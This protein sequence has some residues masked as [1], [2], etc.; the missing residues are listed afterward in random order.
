ATLY[1][2][3]TGRVPHEAP[4][5]EALYRRIL[6]A[7]VSR[8]GRHNPQAP[9]ELEIVLATALERDPLRRYH[10]AEAFADDLQ[11][12]RTRRPI[13]ARSPGP[14]LRVRRWSQRYPYVAALLAVLGASL[15]VVVYLLSDRNEALWQK[16]MALRRASAALAT[17]E[18]MPLRTTNPATA[19]RAA[20]DAARIESPPTPRAVAAV[21]MA[22]HGGHVDVDVPIIGEHEHL[23]DIAPDG[24]LVVWV[25][26]AKKVWRWRI[27]A[28][29][30]E[31][32]GT[33]NSTWLGQNLALSPDLRR[34]AIA[35]DDGPTVVFDLVTGARLE[36]PHPPPVGPR[37]RALSVAWH[38]QQN[39][40]AVG[41]GDYNFADTKSR[42]H[43]WDLDAPE[44]PRWWVSIGAWAWH[45]A[46]V[47]ADTLVVAPGCA[48]WQ[49]HTGFRNHH[50]CAFHLDGTE[51]GFHAEHTRP[52]MALAISGGLV[53]T[54]GHDRR[55][56]LWDCHG[57]AERVVR[58]HPGRVNSVE[59]SSD[60]QSVVT[61]CEDGFVRVFD[62][63][64]SLQTEWAAHGSMPA[65][66]AS[67]DPSGE[68]MLIGVRDRRFLTTRDGR[69]LFEM[70]AQRFVVQNERFLQDGRIVAFDRNTIRIWRDDVGLPAHWLPT[71]CKPVL[72]A[73][74]SQLLS[75]GMDGAAALRDWSGARIWSAK[76]P[77]PGAPS[78]SAWAC[79]DDQGRAYAA[80]DDRRLAIVSPLGELERAAAPNQRSGKLEEETWLRVIWYLSPAP[81]GGMVAASAA[82]NNLRVVARD[83]EGWRTI[84]QV[85]P[86]R[87]DGRGFQPRMP[88]VWVKED[89]ATWRILAGTVRGVMQF[90]LVAGKLE[91]IA[92]E[93]LLP[94]ARIDQMALSPDQRTLAVDIAEGGLHMFVRDAAGWRSRAVLP[95]T[96]L[97]VHLAFARNDR[98]LATSAEQVRILDLDGNLVGLLPNID[99]VGLVSAHRL[100]GDRVLTIAANQIMREWWLDG[101]R[102]LEHARR[103][104]KR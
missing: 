28:D 62:R 30:P 8:L 57:G 11:N 51:C 103:L 80:T 35:G 89:G 64:G 23:F 45:L 13:H 102:A 84:D 97:V 78:R 101:D 4:T 90:R 52:C 61:T 40:L 18:A 1:E 98:L 33:L 55:L 12:V 63:V 38:P 95:F 15:A 22:L 94:D 86:V 73:D 91:Q 16:D 67:F 20:D 74:G 77:L 7:E 34:L 48:L 3:L 79:V 81:G 29:V 14:W 46:F 82:G 17:V 76:M 59:F 49:S 47:D 50:V 100:P 19:L 9:R 5:L 65:L 75:V 10:T 54:G 87:E 104:L 96:T 60:G 36:L 27:G 83:E 6:T 26:R 72:S 58:E 92:D 43:L 2:A 68:R 88:F 93:V 32:V 25:D 21:Q 44:K 39:L 41:T 42:V 66:N 70:P 31:K 85:T 56:V 53:A 99:P 37:E 24:S 69:P 71:G